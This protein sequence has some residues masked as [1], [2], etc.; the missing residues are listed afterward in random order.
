MQQR[1]GERKAVDA[2]HQPRLDLCGAFQKPFVVPRHGDSGQHKE[3]GIHRQKH[4]EDVVAV[5]ANED[6]VQR[7]EQEE[8]PEE[9]AVVAFACGG[10]RDEFAQRPKRHQKKQHH[11]GGGAEPEGGGQHRAHDP[12]AAQA[13]V[14]RVHRRRI[15]PTIGVPLEELANSGG[16]REEREHA[17]DKSDRADVIHGAAAIPSVPARRGVRGR[18]SQASTPPAPAT[19]AGRS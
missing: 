15:E 12:P 13:E 8:D 4:A 18:E 7:R 19:R 6:V 17:G 16:R 10:E 3:R 14:E 2:H 9:R 1:R 5:H 11:S